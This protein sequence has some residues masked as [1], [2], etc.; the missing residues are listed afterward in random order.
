MKTYKWLLIVIVVI[1][2]ACQTSL[3]TKT[4]KGARNGALEGH[5][6]LGPMLPA[7]RE[8]MVEPT[9]AP[10]AYAARQVVIYVQDGKTEIARAQIDVQGK[11]RVSLPA[12]TYVIDINH[13]GIDRGVDLPQVIQIVDGQITQLDIAIDTGVR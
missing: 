13:A 1:L 3:M 4:H 12:G 10:E 7:M 9:P 2:S 5:V 8:G 6:S 11:Y